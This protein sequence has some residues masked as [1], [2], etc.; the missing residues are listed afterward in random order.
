MTQAT[1]ALQELAQLDKKAEVVLSDGRFVAIYKVKLGH[2][3]LSK[4]ADDTIAMVK[5][6]HLTTKV[7]EKPF[8]VKDILNLELKDFHKIVEALNKDIANK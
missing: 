8:E 6:I 7:D 5:L 1:S 4:D 2:V 3:L